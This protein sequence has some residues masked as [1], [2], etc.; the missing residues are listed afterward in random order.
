MAV[1]SFKR[2]FWIWFSKDP[3]QF[4]GIENE[5]RLIRARHLHKNTEFTLVYSEKVLDSETL[6]KLKTFTKKH[7]IKLL[8]FDKELP[9]FLKH[10][11][12]KK[13]YQLAKDEIAYSQ[14]EQGG[15]LAAASDCVRTLIPLIENW[16]NYTD[17]DV[18]FNFSKKRTCQ[19]KSPVVLKVDIDRE[20]LNI[21]IPSLNND[22]MF[23]ARE[24][25]QK[26]LTSDAIHRIRLV[27]K[28]ILKRYS[29]VEAAL[30]QHP[31]RGLSTALDL[32]QDYSA[33][34][35]DFFRKHP[36]AN[37]FAFRKFVKS[38]DIVKYFEGISPQDRKL[39]FGQE[40]MADLTAESLA[41][42]FG[43]YV[44][45]EQIKKTLSQEE[46][47]RSS[48]GLKKITEKMMER[49][50]HRLNTIAVTWISGPINYFSLYEDILPSD[51]I[52]KDGEVLN[53]WLT[54]VKLLESSG[55]ESNH[56]VRYIPSI[57]PHFLDKE[58]IIENPLESIGIF[59]D[60]S[61]ST[62]GMYNKLEREKQMTTAAIT[63]QHA[64]R[65]YKS[66]KV[67]PEEVKSKH[68][69]LKLSNF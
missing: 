12:D 27:Q 16:G 29:D 4:M 65:N 57:S 47:S 45:E 51:A 49:M 28:Q 55:Y 64:W 20:K 38:L 31:I 34:V 60:Q 66:K 54:Y 39:I 37:I 3:A 25:D 1:L 30:F 41:I 53:I 8:D 11:I 6:V 61:W 50:R 23:V 19:V 36:K 24:S 13:I 44:V 67:S 32:H 5:V 17:F 2:F 62:Q 9:H 56:L 10:E 58:A 48:S 46:I 42:A 33:I 40:T 18:R 7:N 59:G 69:T 26:T 35:K 21:P 63:L 52:F 43:K 68:K 22:L 15:N 14:D